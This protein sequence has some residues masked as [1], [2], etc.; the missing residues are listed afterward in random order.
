MAVSESKYPTVVI[1][2]LRSKDFH[3][4]EVAVTFMAETVGLGTD[5]KIGA[6]EGLLYGL[7]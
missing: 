1:I 6:L 7:D 5:S 2:I 4:T 3:Q